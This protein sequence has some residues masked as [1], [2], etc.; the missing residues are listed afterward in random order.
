MQ[1]HKMVLSR[2]AGGLVVLL[3]SAGLPVAAASS[4][5]ALPS[6]RVVVRFSDNGVWKTYQATGYI[7]Y[8]FTSAGSRVG[9]VSSGDWSLKTGNGYLRYVEKIVKK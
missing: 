2:I 8:K 4:A 6:E 5:P 9:S 7:L 1:V 3:A